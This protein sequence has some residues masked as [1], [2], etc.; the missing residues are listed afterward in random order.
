[1]TMSHGL[2][3]FVRGRAGTLMTAFLAAGVALGL[4]ACSDATGPDGQTNMTVLLTDAPGDLENAWV[5]VTEIRLQGQA[6]D[7]PTGV[8]LLDESTGLIELTALEDAENNEELLRDVPIPSGTYGQLRFHIGGAVVET[9]EG[10][11]FSKDGAQHPGGEPTTG[12]LICP[13]C[14]ETGIKVNM[15]GGAL[16]VEGESMIL[17]LDF[18]VNESFGREAG[19]A[20]TWVMEPTITSSEME[21]SGSVAGFVDLDEGVEI[22]ECADE[23]RSVADFVPQATLLGVPDSEDPVVKTS[24]VDETGEYTISFMQPGDWEMRFDEVDFSGGTLVFEAEVSPSDV[25][26]VESGLTSEAD[27]TITSA[28]CVTE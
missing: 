8:T 28:E 13:S 11:V 27:Y 9:T 1:M 5:E 15:P 24:S 16:Q 23:A 6:V 10:D 2:R 18:D 4:T 17:V 20:N 7:S 21:L 26:T 19:M 12:D 3:S 14:T 25:V 22:P